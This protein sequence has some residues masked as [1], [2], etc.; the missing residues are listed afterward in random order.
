[1]PAQAATIGTAIRLRRQEIGLTQEELAERIGDG[2][3]QS[4]ISRMERD[5]VQMPRPA[6]FRAIAAALELQPGELLLLA[7][8]PGAMTESARPDRTDEHQEPLALADDPIGDIQND[9]TG[10]RLSRVLEQSHV[11]QSRFL[12]VAR[13]YEQ[14][15]A[16]WRRHFG[17]TVDRK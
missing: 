7:G 17:V 5:R 10:R 16:H 9:N 15:V 13:R 14:T 4:D 6:R 11:V 12:D 1:M 2:I 3:R 8:W